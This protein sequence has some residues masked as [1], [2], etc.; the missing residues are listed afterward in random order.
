[1]ALWNNLVLKARRVVSDD[2]WELLERDL[3]DPADLP[4]DQGLFGQ[5]ALPPGGMWG[6]LREETLI[7]PRPWRNDIWVE[8]ND[9]TLILDRGDV[10]NLWR[11][12]ATEGEQTSQT[13]SG[14]SSDLPSLPDEDIDLWDRLDEETIVLAQ[15][16]GQIWSIPGTRDMADY[17]PRRAAGWAIKKLE[18][19]RG[20]VYYVLKNLRDSTYLKLD[21]Q[22]VYLWELMDGSESVQDLAVA[23]FVKYQSLSIDWL[24][25]FLT[26]LHAKGFLVEDQVDVY[27]AAER[28]VERRSLDYWLGQ[29]GTFLFHSELA[30]KNVDGFFA[31]VYR[32]GGKLLYTRPALIMLIL[33]SLIGIP[34]F[35]YLSLRTDLSIITGATGSVGWGVLSLVAAQIVT[36]FIHESAH[37]LTT[38][39]YGRTIRRAGVGLYFGMPAF[40]V[41]TS[42]IWME[43]RGPRLAVT[44]AG[45]FSGFF[46]G[47][48]VSLVILLNP[49]TI[50]AGIA[51]QF[52][53]WC[54]LISFVNLNPLLKLD[55]YYIL[56]DWLELPSLRERSLAFVRTELIPR[57]RQK[58]P[59]SHE[60]RIFAIFG[61]L[62]LLWSGVAIYLMMQLYGGKL[63]EL[64]VHFLGPQYGW[65]AVVVVGAAVGV[66]L[67][68]QFTA[69]QHKK[70]VDEQTAT[71]Q[72]S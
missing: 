14:V 3:R 47:G 12:V 8:A 64:S 53:S 52:A 63:Y 54:Y 43:P 1:M 58:A 26:Q 29:I 46:L 7:L 27:Q 6:A 41:D 15:P 67:I 38:K 24:M 65:V 34:A 10:Q 60:E 50:W 5:V 68:R 23:C 61:M 21:E 37:A 19:A 42:D 22:Q 35:F 17:R 28:E 11:A 31:A 56:M 2:M 40:F 25:G 4:P 44:W 57:L 20:E 55:G 39:H 51:Y 13:P 59:L 16:I 33:V 49:T 36:I 70:Q 72:A 48:A 18:T 66:V 32:L 9:E 62:A 45:P 69:G 30:L 71:D